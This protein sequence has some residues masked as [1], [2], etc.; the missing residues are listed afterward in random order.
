MRRILLV[1]SLVT[2]VALLNAQNIIYVSPGGMGTGAI[3]SPIDLQG[4]LDLANNNG[5]ADELRLVEG[6]YNG[7]PYT[8]FL[9][10][11]DKM[12][13]LL[14]G[15][16]NA[17]YTSQ[18]EV[19]NNT[20]LHGGDT[21]RVLY[22]NGLTA[23]ADMTFGLE[24]LFIEH[25]YATDANGGGI[26]VACG[27]NVATDSKIMLE[28][29]YVMVFNC[30]SGDTG[31]GG[32]LF[33]D[34][35]FD[36]YEC[37][38][39]FNSAASNGGAIFSTYRDKT[40]NMDRHI[41][42]T[43][44]NSNEN[45]GNQGS[46]I[47]NNAPGLYIT[48]SHFYGYVDGQ[49]LG[50]GSAVY[51]STGGTL[52][53]DRTRF[54]DLR[55]NYWG[56]A[57]QA[58]DASVDITNSLFVNNKAGIINGYGTIA[59]YHNSGAGDQLLTISNCTFIENEGQSNNY[60][61]VH[62]RGNGDDKVSIFN[63]VFWDNGPTP[64]YKESGL[65]EM[66]Y[67]T[68]EFGPINFENTSFIYDFN[69]GLNNSYYPTATSPTIDVGLEFYAANTLG[70]IDGNIRVLGDEIDLGCVE[71]S[72]APSMIEVSPAVIQ[73]NNDPN[74]QVGEILV[75]D[76]PQDSHTLSL[77]DGNGTNDA[78][79]DLF[80]IQ[81]DELWF[82]PVADYETKSSY[83]VYLRALDFSG[84]V[85]DEAIVINV[86]DVN[87]APEVVGT[88][89]DQVGV[90]GTPLDF[91]IG[92]DVIIDPDFGDMIM[93]SATLAN[94]DPLPAWLSFSPGQRRF[95]GTPTTEEVLMIKATMTDAVSQSA[96]VTF[97]LTIG[98]TGIWD[99]Y[100]GVVRVYPNPASDRLYVE[101]LELNAMSYRIHDLNG[102]LLSNGTLSGNTSSID[103]SRLDSGVYLLT[104]E[105]GS[106]AYIQIWEKH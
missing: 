47:W 92:N 87:E 85:L 59:Y 26:L 103:V 81:N 66:R 57:V 25:G 67:C 75:T 11:S 40:Q 69:P 76:E 93:W 19:P 18:S 51:T 5:M 49:T 64:I 27:S 44:F 38:F 70:D 9:N 16:W 83:N 84:K 79:N 24:Y 12:D 60:S 42:E 14:S 50:N 6:N 95:T 98:A 1:I 36:L 35:G 22:I 33:T 96:S 45:F 31:S 32:G 2:C 43:T 91:S 17:N 105:S 82:T 71:Y 56:S 52:Y 97:N 58:W 4:A 30:R 37:D 41:T 88:M 10:T 55:I 78:D 29:D 63:S 72:F 7:A 89:D 62:F 99:N 102:R 8:Y 28:M 65:S 77:T 68:S 90:V 61:A 39:G 21:E 54:L 3:D 53:I 34:G 100:D 74:S 80:Y 106:E 101:L 15:S 94:D 23:N 46:S 104:I 73:E 20:R 86:T 13:I 48:D